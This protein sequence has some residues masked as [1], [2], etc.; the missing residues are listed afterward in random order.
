[1]ADRIDDAALLPWGHWLR[2]KPS[3]G[4][5]ILIDEDG[6][7]WESVRDA[8]FHGKLGFKATSA[9]FREVELERMLAYLLGA[10]GP[11]GTSGLQSRGGDLFQ[12][13]AF[14]FFYRHWLG[15]NG[16]MEQDPR[17][18]VQDAQLTPEGR[19]VAKMLLATR[20]PGLAGLHP[21]VETLLFAEGRVEEVSRASFEKGNQDVAQMR[22]AFVRER[23]GRQPSIS[24][25]HRDASLRMPLVRTIW[26]QTFPDERSRDAYYVW[27]S[28]QLERWNAWGDIAYRS[29]ASALTQHLLSLLA[30]EMADR[31]NRGPGGPPE[32]A[33]PQGGGAAL[34]PL[35]I[36]WSG[37]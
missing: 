37:S 21:G 12:D 13:V 5:M 11:F 28:G 10:S 23:I 26:T 6:C 30:S 22:Y 18:Q 4:E 31:P 24:L 7:E 2:M 9:H 25:V 15:A 8:F 17:T 16:L 3:G 27:M 19:S 32:H 36:K 35:A 34:P 20:P 14:S 1:M 29:G 33:G